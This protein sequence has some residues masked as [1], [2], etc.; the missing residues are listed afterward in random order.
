MPQPFM[1]GAK[2]TMLS[3]WEEWCTLFSLSFTVTLTNHELLLAYVCRRGQIAISS[4]CV[5]LQYEHQFEM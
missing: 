2:L 3:V 5:T 4:Q 1:A